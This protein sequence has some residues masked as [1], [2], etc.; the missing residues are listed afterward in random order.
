MP[1]RL[2]N[3][4]RWFF[5]KVVTLP[6]GSTKRLS[7]WPAINKAW[8]AK[9][10][11]EDAILRLL[12]EARNPTNDH[13]TKEEIPTFEKFVE[14]R[15]LPTYPA[16]AGNRATTTKEKE[17]HLRLYL[18]PVLGGML[19]DEIKGEAVDRLFASLRSPRPVGTDGKRSRVLS[20]KTIK[21]VR[22]TLRRVLA[23]AVEWGVIEKIPALPKVK[24]PETGW[25]F[26]TQEESDRLI[27]VARD[28]EERALL[29]FPLR[30]GARA[31][32][33]LAVEWGDIDWHR[34]EIVFRRSSTAGTVGPTK[35]GRE[36]RVPVTVGLLEALRKIKH[37]RGKLVFCRQDGQPLKIGQLHER[38]WSACR[39][40]GLREIRWHDLRHS[41]ASQLAIAGVPLNQIQQWLGHS[42]INMTMRYAHLAPGSGANLIAALE[43]RKSVA[44]GWQQRQTEETK[45]SDIS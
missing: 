12:D 19:L 10:A 35:S 38:L 2:D 6:D 24:V 34:S 36:R 37:L 29:K 20:P 4:G 25:D 3:R 11:E 23:S 44:A 16:A 15:W 30:T 1:V 22:A 40:A 13:A 17:L 9:K 14:E 32:E 5:R 31:G 27:A 7:G 18:K 28:D 43:T 33:L 21:N 26:F 41:F 39:R 8:A 45:L 42:T